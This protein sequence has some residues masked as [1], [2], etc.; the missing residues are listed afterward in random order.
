MLP[1][2][3]NI[4]LEEGKKPQDTEDHLVLS[5]LLLFFFFGGWYILIL[6]Q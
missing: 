1:L 3:I 2:Y 6:H 4:I 5:L